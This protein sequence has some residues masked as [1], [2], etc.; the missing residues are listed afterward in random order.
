MKILLNNPTTTKNELTKR[1]ENA[2]NK[3]KE[4]YI[5]SAYLTQWITN[6]KLYPKCK[7][8]LFLVGTDFGLTRKKACSDVIDWLPKRFYGNFLSVPHMIENGFHPKIIA[9]KDNHNKYHCIIGSSNL[10]EAA[11]NSNYEANIEVKLTYKEYNGI[12][13]WLEDIG[14]ECQ[15]I[16]DDWL[17]Q[18]KERNFKRQRGRKPK[19]PTPVVI[20]RIPTG[21]SFR[22]SILE[23]RKNEKTFK[24]IKGR[25]LKAMIFSSKGKISNAVFW[26]KFWSLWHD[27]PSRMQGSG[28]QFSGKSA[29]W[30]EACKSFIRIINLSSALSELNLDNVVKQEIDKLANSN[31]PVRG[32]WFSE[33]LCHFF[34]DRYP[35][36]NNPVKIYLKMNKWRS[37]R[38]L[39]NG[40]KYI[41]LAK[42]L[43]NA[44]KQNKNGPSNMP[45]L[46]GIIWLW[47]YRRGL[48]D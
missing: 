47:C 21:K 40:G 18:Y 17:N 11:F 13:N 36:V 15:V 38:G 44:L 43:R 24:E 22:Y 19:G 14:K 45:E 32:A 46:D 9:W 34:P 48:L 42:K 29:N 35:L 2:I 6:V 25:L 41:D 23:R 3:A 20:L 26:N 5:A 28:L 31:N 16:D 10:T 7:N 30:K 8:F 37:Q 33:M 4:L 12:V 1:Y 27:H 39:S